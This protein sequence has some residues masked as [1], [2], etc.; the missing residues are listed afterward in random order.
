MVYYWLAYMRRRTM[1][2]GASRVLPLSQW[3]AIAMVVGLVASWAVSAGALRL[4]TVL[5]IRSGCGS[6]SRC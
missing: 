4:Q 6:A 3:V 1:A 5:L 2:W